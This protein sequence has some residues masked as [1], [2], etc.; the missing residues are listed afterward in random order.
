MK[1]VIKRDGTEEKFNPS[2]IERAI[3]KAYT[4]CSKEPNDEL[5]KTI[6]NVLSESELEKLEIEKIQDII[7]ASLMEHD[8]AIGKRYVLYRNERARMRGLV[9]TFNEI[10]EIEDTDVKNENANVNGNTPAGQMMK[11]ASTS[12]K[13]YAEDHLISRKFVELQQNNLVH[14]H[15][16]DYY[17]SK[18]TTCVQHDLAKLFKG[19]FK[20]GHGFINEPN[21]LSVAVDLAAISLQ[22]NQNEQHGGQAIVCWDN[23][24][25]PYAKKSFREHFLK[26]YVDHYESVELPND[27]EDYDA[28]VAILEEYAPKIEKQFGVIELDNQHLAEH[29]VRT[30]KIAKRELIRESDQAAQAFIYNMNTMHSRGGGQVVFSSVNTGTDFSQEGRIIN[31][32]LLKALYKGLGKGETSIFPIVIWKVKEQVN[33]SDADFAKAIKKPL[34][35]LNGDIQF[36][37]PNFDLFVYACHVAAKRLF[38]TFMFLDTPFNRHE[39]WD[40]NDPNRFYY[41]GATIDKPVA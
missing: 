13:M 34:A 8:N 40:I 32:S 14:I 21:R 38:P 5:I 28:Y 18:T 37:T 6:V 16:E 35:A 7:E 20:T 12:S 29:Y 27:E 2:K 19:G 10:V 9:K 24:L 26:A 41:E 39:K 36:E 17:P 33:W 4:A 3:K 15:D 30:F 22:T 25:V 1:Y 31:K 23:A 11:F